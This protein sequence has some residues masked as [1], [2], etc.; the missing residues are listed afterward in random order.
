MRDAMWLGSVHKTDADGSR[1]R[2]FT[3]MHHYWA[4]AAAVKLAIYIRRFSPT[5]SCRS[6]ERHFDADDDGWDRCRLHH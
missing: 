2:L 6:R 4:A 3:A 5:V 1:I